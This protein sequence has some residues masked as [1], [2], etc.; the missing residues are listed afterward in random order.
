MEAHEEVQMGLTADSLRD[1]LM[2]ALRCLGDLFREEHQFLKGSSNGDLRSIGAV[3]LTGTQNNDGVT[4]DDGTR[5]IVHKT[6]NPGIWT[7]QWDGPGIR[8]LD[9]HTVGQPPFAALTPHIPPPPPAQP[10]DPD[11]FTGRFWRLIDFPDPDLNGFSHLAL[12][13]Q[14]QESHSADDRPFGFLDGHTLDGFVG[15]N[16]GTASEEIIQ[17]NGERRRVDRTG[18]HWELTVW[19]PV[20]HEGGGTPPPNGLPT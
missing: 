19:E 11:P 13:C 15:L 20:L 16:D 2:V 17:N 14:G 12:Q 7:F 10:P 6:E 1:G 5:W 8:F 4:M 9:G 3:A 18:T